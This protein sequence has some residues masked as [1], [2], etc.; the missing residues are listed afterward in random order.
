MLGGWRLWSQVEVSGRQQRYMA[1]E[2]LGELELNLGQH[3][4][5]SLGGFGILDGLENTCLLE[6]LAGIL[7]LEVACMGM[8]NRHTSSIEG[9]MRNKLDGSLVRN[10]RLNAMFRSSSRN[11]IS[12]HRTNTESNYT[13]S[14][15]D[16]HTPENVSLSCM[17]S[18]VEPVEMPLDNLAFLAGIVDSRCGHRDADG[19][20]AKGQGNC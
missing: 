1:E 13:N 10:N 8:F 14:P 9:S 11:S 2:A 17:M 18:R 3:I 5:A 16:R 15:A 19:R 4:G 6:S 12:T 7:L 20:N